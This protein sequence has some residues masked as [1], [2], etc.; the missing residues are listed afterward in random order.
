MRTWG[1]ERNE[2]DPQGADMTTALNRRRHGRF[3]VPGLRCSLGRVVNISG[4]GI[5]VRTLWPWGR[6]RV[7]TFDTESGPI[8]VHAERVRLRWRLGLFD[9]GYRLLDAPPDLYRRLTSVRRAP[10]GLRIM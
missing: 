3:E 9:V 1:R 10:T 2:T 6:R 8:V 5:A 7:I 4:G